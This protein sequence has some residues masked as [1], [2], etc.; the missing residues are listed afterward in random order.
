MREERAEAAKLK[1]LNSPSFDYFARLK[2]SMQD[3]DSDKL[4]STPSANK[5][6]E[7]YYKV[8]KAPMMSLLPGKYVPSISEWYF[9]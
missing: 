3:T 9:N 2:K 8:Q 5:E 7:D 4:Y 1:L 6:D